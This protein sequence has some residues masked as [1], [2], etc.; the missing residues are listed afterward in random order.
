MRSAY[1]IP[2]RRFAT[3]GGDAETRWAAI[4]I[5]GD[6][7]RFGMARQSPDAAHF[8]LGKERVVMEPLVLQQ[9]FQCPRTAAKP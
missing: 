5:V 8:G 4:H 1:K 9:G 7:G 3:G 2:E 6:I